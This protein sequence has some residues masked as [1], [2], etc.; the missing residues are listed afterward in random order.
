MATSTGGSGADSSFP[1]G[2]RGTKRPAGEES[3]AA[4]PAERHS[5]CE[6]TASAISTD[7]LASPPPDQ[8]AV[9]M[10]DPNSRSTTAVGEGIDVTPGLPAPPGQPRKEVLANKSTALMPEQDGQTGFKLETSGEG[11]GDFAEEDFDGPIAES[12]ARGR[13]LLGLLVLQ[14]SSSFVLDHYQDLLREHVVVTL[15]LTML[16]G[17]GGNAGNQSAIKV[18]RGLATGR[19]TPHAACALSVIGDQAIVGILLGT[20]LAAGG[21]VRVWVTEGTTLRDASAISSSL[22]LIVMASVLLGSA[23]PFGFARAGVDPANA[24]TTIQVA[25]DIVGVAVTCVTCSLVL[26]QLDQVLTLPL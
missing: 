22:F 3:P 15:F 4:R 12:Y 23:L 7:E 8:A 9:A 16:V 14:S 20:A 11:G 21:F 5:A 2:R 24:G 19:F 18:I 25:M 6:S 1:R 13:W 17:A 10:E 26:T